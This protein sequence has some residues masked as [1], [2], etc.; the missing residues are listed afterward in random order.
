MSHD[1]PHAQHRSTDSIILQIAKR[2]RNEISD[3]HHKAEALE[4]LCDA[5]C[6]VPHQRR[7]RLALLRGVYSAV[8]QT[9]RQHAS[10]APISSEA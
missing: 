5:F 9:Q 6:T 1:T 8:Q 3:S 2:I 7:Q 4:L 10:A